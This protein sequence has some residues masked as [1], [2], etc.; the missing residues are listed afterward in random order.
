MRY[1]N[2]NPAIVYDQN[3]GAF[4]NAEVERYR[5]KEYRA[6]AMMQIHGYPIWNT[7]PAAGRAKKAQETNKHQKKVNDRR[8]FQKLERLIA[9]NFVERVDLKVG[10]DH[11]GQVT[12]EQAKK[13]LTQFVDAARR[14][15]K[16]MG[17]ELRYLYV[18]QTT[19]KTGRPSKRPHH[20]LII[21]SCGDRAIIEK[22]WV[23]GRAHVEPL[24][25]DKNG[26]GG[27]ATYLHQHLHGAKRWVGSRNLVDPQPSFPKSREIS[28]RKSC[29]IATDYEAARTYFEK[30]YPDH[31][32]LDMQV[33]F[34]EYVS[35]AYFYVRM[36]LR[37]AWT[38]W[39]AKGGGKYAKVQ[40]MRRRD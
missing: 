9:E 27:L 32:F 25:P 26:L 36:R 31:I 2:Y 35:G 23:H 8:M 22:L 40:S 5:V 37:D 29:E 38:R 17:I 3:E 1:G 30:K 20:H 11:E 21:T 14:K 28:R 4:Q 18:P 6:G 10:L 24:Q 12:P 39:N 19:T 15:Y 13:A 33:S 34:S 16:R 7:K